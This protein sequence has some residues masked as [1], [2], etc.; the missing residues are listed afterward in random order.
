MPIRIVRV[1]SLRDGLVEAGDGFGVA[2]WLETVETAITPEIPLRDGR[3]VVFRHGAA[4]YCAAWPDAKLLRRI[5]IRMAR[6]AKLPALALPADVRLRRAG[7]LRFAFNYGPEPLSVPAAEARDFVVGG[8]RLE[9]A[10]VA[11]WREPR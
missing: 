2:R 1:E 10:G 11:I 5:F 7:G 8:P 3:G 9:P 6:D 4:R